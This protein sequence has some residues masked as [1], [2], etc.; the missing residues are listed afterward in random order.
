MQQQQRKESLNLANG[1]KG[2]PGGAGKGSSKLIAALIIAAIVGGYFWFKSPTSAPAP[3]QQAVVTQ[4]S[5]PKAINEVP[6]TVQKFDLAQALAKAQAAPKGSDEAARLEEAKTYMASAQKVIDQAL[7]ETSGE[8]I[9]IADTSGSMNGDM[10][11]VAQVNTY[12]SSLSTSRPVTVLWVDDAMRGF[13]QLTPGSP[14]QWI[15]G[16]G[17][18]LQPG[19]DFLA[20]KGVRPGLLI[21]LTD[22]HCTNFPANP[23][24]PVMWMLV[25]PA[26]GFNA[27]W[28]V[29]VGK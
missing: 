8:V 10:L 29:K 5:L 19:F 18:S 27:P 20:K 1:G 6:G 26:G 17:T 7:K 16:G 21:Y 14:G 3:A 22:G 24:Y 4:A 15:G 28:G 13:E 2:G 25:S 12:L 11:K 9:V 23:G